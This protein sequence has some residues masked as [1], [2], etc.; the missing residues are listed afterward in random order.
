VVKA[1]QPVRPYG[2]PHQRAGVNLGVVVGFNEVADLEKMPKE[3][4]TT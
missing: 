2:S 3:A 4:V 1:K